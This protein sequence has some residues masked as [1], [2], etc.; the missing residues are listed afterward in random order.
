MCAGWLKDPRRCAGG[1]SRQKRFARSLLDQRIP[2][3]SKAYLRDSKRSDRRCGDFF[4]G[5]GGKRLGKALDLLDTRGDRDGLFMRV[6][7]GGGSCPPRQGTKNKGT[8]SLEVCMN[9]STPLH[10][11][12]R[13][14]PRPP[15]GRDVQGC[16]HVALSCVFRDGLCVWG[17][18]STLRSVPNR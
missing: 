12:E 17:W 8:K 15:K 16:V 10:A 13:K 2:V 18:K 7:A 9:K 1:A 4:C 14:A 5:E 11:V 6:R 3:A